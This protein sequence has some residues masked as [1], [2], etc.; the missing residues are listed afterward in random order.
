MLL[1]VCGTTE[2]GLYSNG[3]FV[4]CELT[5]LD[6]TS[7][8]FNTVTSLFS[9]DALASDAGTRPRIR[10]LRV[11]SVRR[12]KD[13]AAFD[14]NPVTNLKLL[15][16][17]TKS[18]SALGVLSRG[19]LLPMFVGRSGGKR[20]DA[21][22][23]GA[24][25]YFADR[26]T[27]S[28]QYS[29]YSEH[30][31]SRIM[32]VANVALGKSARLSDRD[33]GLVKP[34]PGFDSVQG[35]G[36]SAD[37][38]DNEFVVYSQEQQRLQFL[39][40]FIVDEDVP[41]PDCPKGHGL[42]ERTIDEGG[43][44]CCDSQQTGCSV[45]LTAGTAVFT[46]RTCDYDICAA[47]HSMVRS[48]QPA[49][50]G[51]ALAA[52][53]P[54]KAIAIKAD[55][56][57][58][59]EAQLSLDDV[60]DVSD[61]LDNVLTG[62][63]SDGAQIPLQ[64]VRVVANV[65]DAMAQVYVFQQYHN[66]SDYEI[67]AKYVFPLS[68][69]AAVCGF[70]AYINGKHVVG[71]VKRKETARKEYKKAVESGQG[72]YLMDQE[73]EAPNVF[74][75][76]VG[77]LPANSD[78]IIKIRYV[79]ELEV[80]MY[81]ANSSAMV[82]RLPNSLSPVTCDKALDTRT[83][84]ATSTIGMKAEDVGKVSISVSVEM[85]NDIVNMFCATHAVEMKRSATKGMINLSNA[86]TLEDG[87]ILQIV[88]ADPHEPR[89]WIEEDDTGHRACAIAVYPRFDNQLP[90]DGVD[91]VVAIDASCSMSGD[92]LEDAKKVSLLL[93]NG[94]PQK[95]GA[96]FN[97]VCYGSFYEELFPVATKINEA[98]IAEAILYVNAVQAT[99]GSTNLWQPLRVLG[100]IAS[101]KAAS[102]SP[103]VQNVIV[104]SDGAIQEESHMLHV[105]REHCPS[106]RLF[107]CGVGTDC[108]RS[109]L[110][111]LARAGGGM[112]AY[113][114]HARKSGWQRKIAAIVSNCSQPGASKIWTHW[115]TFDNNPEQEYPMQAPRNISSLFCGQRKLVY[116]YVDH[117]TSA[118]LHGEI[119]GKE[120]S[121]IA[122]TSNLRL[123]HGTILH[124]LAARAFIR[125]FEDGAYCT[126]DAENFAKKEEMKATIIDLSIK[127]S[128]V[129]KFTSFIAVENRTDDG[130]DEHALVRTPPITQ[131]AESVTSDL[132]TSQG[133]Q[134]PRIHCR[135][136]KETVDLV[137]QTMSQLG[138][139]PFGPD[140]GAR[141]ERF[142]AIFKDA[143]E[144]VCE[145]LPQT[146]HLRGKLGGAY[147]AFDVAL[148][149][150]VKISTLTA[151]GNLSAK[152]CK[153]AKHA[154]DDSIAELDT[155]SEDS[156]KDSTLAMQ[157]I[158]DNLTLWTER[159]AVDT[160]KVLTVHDEVMTESE[161]ESDC[162]ENRFSGIG[163]LSSSLM[164]E[165][166]AEFREAFNLFDADG[167]GVVATSNLGNL[168]RALGEPLRLSPP[169]IS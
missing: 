16:H 158:R 155:L 95:Q 49:V 89:M 21:G 17:A 124:T 132:L 97:V 9:E 63:Q 64:T 77:N 101:K 84:G 146:N 12:G 70:E 112:S 142:A 38:A 40:E 54:T 42:R 15:F 113:F 102:T 122:S 10:V 60:Q 69:G 76:S 144:T 110:Q 134:E 136:K 74:T 34:P 143:I 26:P 160:E 51:D 138:A 43:R 133:F 4:G 94:L 96:R 137:M 24:G 31:K 107:S 131:L 157:M 117:C 169:T 36:G 141:R 99:W 168:M 8:G 116:G 20:T 153:L 115:R 27:T 44:F 78:V 90:L 166:V 151:G 46:C 19:L 85:P 65:V 53:V 48:L 75:V 52:P 150:K 62:L 91:F 104:V 164:E 125:D 55:R 128:L 127:Y 109:F 86:T 92:T 156:Y 162:P 119:D 56:A 57:D 148:T 30:T 98:T 111:A 39:V 120:W 105:A 37:F 13:D 66:A 5:E 81:D 6:D 83:Q 11:Y 129:T 165:Q 14:Q 3:C 135:T 130:E 67:E 50:T 103:F 2:G 73:D 68:D 167:S 71:E 35:V 152:T 140:L 45:N 126:T 7:I 100:L 61:P 82:F 149:S 161:S 163:S 32:L 93:L 41:V 80:E 123:T 23:L 1:D 87:F 29:S 139:T 47:C 108:S 106:M 154:F 159:D 114:D 118:E 59:P 72:A 22:N 88:M 58:D 18:A 79:I 25:I 121:V 147:T 28:V 145:A 33:Q